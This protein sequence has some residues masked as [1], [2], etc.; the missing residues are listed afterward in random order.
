MTAVG[1]LAEA[2][3]YHPQYTRSQEQRAKTFP[4]ITT[5]FLPLIN[6]CINWNKNLITKDHIL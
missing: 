5:I 2:V 3:W 6:I 1:D 4:S